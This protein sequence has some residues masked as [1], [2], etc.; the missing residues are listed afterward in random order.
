[1]S[2][3]LL[4]VID[5]QNDFIDGVLGT[6]DAQA[7]VDKVADKIQ[8][9][10]GDIVFT[11]DTHQEDDYLETN[12][13]KHLPI[14]HCIQGTKG[15]EVNQVIQDAS[16]II[17]NDDEMKLPFNTKVWCKDQFAIN[18]FDLPQSFYFYDE[19]QFCGLCTDICVISN[20]IV[21]KSYLP[22]VPIIVDASCCAGTTPEL[23]SEALNVMRSCQ[24]DIINDN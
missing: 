8:N 5:M 17:V 18:T 14:L 9:W 12:E 6:P 3:K 24:I 22:E 13:G 23:H 11:L 1:M 15:W 20:A 7:I 2:N 4:M 10:D 19:I 16:N 21:F